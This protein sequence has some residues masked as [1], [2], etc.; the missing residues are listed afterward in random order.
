MSEKDGPKYIINFED[1]SPGLRNLL[2]NNNRVIVA[3][4]RRMQ[5]LSNAVTPLALTG[6]LTSAADPRVLDY[7]GPRFVIW[8]TF[9]GLLGYKMKV[10]LNEVYNKIGLEIRRNNIFESKQNPGRNSA[11]TS[12][13]SI[14]SEYPV[15]FVDK[16]N[17]LVFVKD[18]NE[19]YFRFLYQKGFLGDLGLMPWEHRGYLRE[20]IATPEYKAKAKHWVGYLTKDLK[21]RM[22]E[23]KN[24]FLTK[25]REKVRRRFADR[26]K[27]K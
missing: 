7:L 20:P 16:Q 26:E 13:V 23:R 3:S 18:S 11:F 2:L 24:R 19:E 12:I 22:K 4:I 9:F 6:L 10:D 27:P 15:F 25:T 21:E 1:L 17:N 14:V 5:N 8:G